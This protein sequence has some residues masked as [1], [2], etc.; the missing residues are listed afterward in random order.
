MIDNRN[1]WHLFEFFI[2][3]ICGIRLVPLGLTLPLSYSD[4]DFKTESVK[5]LVVSLKKPMGESTSEFDKHAR[6][7]E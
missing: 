4:I 6:I 7:V 5:T 1:V 2:G 3:Q